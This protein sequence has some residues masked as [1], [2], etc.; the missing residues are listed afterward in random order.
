MAP[1]NAPA[2]PPP[3][4]RADFVNV[5]AYIRHLELQVE[6]GKIKSALE[7]ERQAVDRASQN[8]EEL[9]LREEQEVLDEAVN[10]EDVGGAEELDQVEEAV[11]NLFLRGY[12]RSTNPGKLIVGNRQRFTCQRTQKIENGQRFF[13]YCATRAENRGNKEKMCRASTVVEK[14]EN[15]EIT[16]TTTPKLEQHNHMVEESKAVKWRIMN[17]MEALFQ[18]DLTT[19]PSQVRKRILLKFKILYQNKP[20]IWEEVI[21]LLPSNDAID[22]RLRSVRLRSL[23]KLPRSREDLNIENL[24]ENMGESGG[25]NI[26]VLD[27]AKLWRE[28]DFR[29]IFRDVDGFADDVAPDR[30]VVFTTDALLSQLA[31]SAKWSQVKN[32]FCNC[33]DLTHVSLVCK[34]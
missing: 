33:K 4:T 26:K 5:D 13:Y 17:D 14:K 12:D 6:Y 19:L 21:S 10:A 3:M 29:A 16:L 23:G 34:D 32:L 30:V 15:G 22:K 1:L 11:E 28:E 20:E 25:G 9:L 24:L 18:E 7:K 2:S 8:R 27:S 31:L